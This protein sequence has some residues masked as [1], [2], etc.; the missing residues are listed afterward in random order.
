MVFKVTISPTALADIEA[1]FLN[2]VEIAP[3]YAGAWLLELE[4]ATAS[5]AELPLRCGLAYE[6]HAFRITVRQMLHGKGGHKYRVLFTVEGDEVRV[7]H[8]RHTRQQ[9]LEKDDFPRK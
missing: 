2:L 1:H 5:L 9:P 6:S 8:V 4:T 3:E 7:H